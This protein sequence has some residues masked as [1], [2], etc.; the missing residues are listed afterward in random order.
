MLN[1]TEVIITGTLINEKTAFLPISINNQKITFVH[2]NSNNTIGLSLSDG[3]IIDPD[4][5]TYI[6]IEQI[7]KVLEFIKTIIDK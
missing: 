1:K 4:N 2:Y 6:D 5:V 7:N 3:H